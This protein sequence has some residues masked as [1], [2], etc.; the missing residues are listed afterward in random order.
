TTPPEKVLSLVEKELLPWVVT[1]N[2]PL[3]KDMILAKIAEHSGLSQEA[4]LKKVHTI[5]GRKVKNQPSEKSDNHPDPLPLLWW[6]FLV[7]LYFAEPS[8]HLPLDT[9]ENFIHSEL[10]ADPFWHDI[11]INCL[12]YL[13]QGVSPAC[14]EGDIPDTLDSSLITAFTPSVRAN[15]TNSEVRFKAILRKNALEQIMLELKKHSIK[16]QIEY[17][18]MVLKKDSDNA[19]DH[20]EKILL[21]IADLQ[22]KYQTSHRELMDLKAKSKKSLDFKQQPPIDDDPRESSSLFRRVFSQ[23]KSDL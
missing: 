22:L 15:L 6:E 17:L 9:L 16:K 7:H 2:H 4:L 23:E 14:D 20:Q 5:K 3:Q 18:K 19:Q 1:V 11:M 8:D 13:K 12:A 21:A 10:L